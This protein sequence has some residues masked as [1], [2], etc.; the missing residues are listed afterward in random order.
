M[1]LNSGDSDVVDLKG[2]VLAIP[3]WIPSTSGIPEVKE[4]ITSIVSPGFGWSDIVREESVGSTTSQVDEKVEFLIEGSHSWVVC[5]DPWVLYIIGEFSKL[6]ET[7]WW[8]S[9]GSNFSIVKEEF[10][11]L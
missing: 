11:V 1:F 6:P 2:S 5:S 9:D 10:D 4:C 7:S 8:R 3:C